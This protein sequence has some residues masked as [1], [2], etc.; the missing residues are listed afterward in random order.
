MRAQVTNFQCPAC[1][2]PLQFDGES[3]K[4]KCEYCGS[5]FPVQEI[6]ALYGEKIDAAAD[7]AAAAA[8][9][10]PMSNVT[11]DGSWDWNE[12]GSDWGVQFK[13]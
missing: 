4:L 5:L 8:T 12:A 10:E 11:E 6:E 2:G 7:S 1:T 13:R 3:G 9:A